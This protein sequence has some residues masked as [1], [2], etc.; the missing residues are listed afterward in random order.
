M[1][2]EHLATGLTVALLA[3]LALPAPAGA[4]TARFKGPIAGTDNGKITLVT[5][6]KRGKV[7]KVTSFAVHRL[8]LQ[9]IGGE[10]PTTSGQ[11]PPLDLRVNAYRQFG[12]GWDFLTFYG[13]FSRDYERVRGELEI[14][15]SLWWDVDDY[16]GTARHRYFAT[17]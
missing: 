5:E 10:T 8:P 14:D 2:S 16:C 1:K 4:A 17:R 13:R 6:V 7:K 9:C 3:A 12:I 11:T 15:V